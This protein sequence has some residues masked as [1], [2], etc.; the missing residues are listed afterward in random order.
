MS[1]WDPDWRAVRRQRSHRVRRRT[2]GP[3]AVSKVGWKLCR[4]SADAAQFGF[5]FGLASALSRETGRRAIASDKVTSWRNPAVPEVALRHS[6][7]QPRLPAGS[8]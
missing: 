7:P 3:E 5:G 6:G 8:D 4:C 2:V 1:L